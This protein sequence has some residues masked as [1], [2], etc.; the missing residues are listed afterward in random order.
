[1]LLGQVCTHWGLN[2]FFL[3]NPIFVI[4]LNF[5]Q[6]NPLRKQYLSHLSSENCEINCI[7]FDSPRAFQKHQECPQILIHFSIS[8]LSGFHWE[9][10]SIINSFHIIAPN[11]LKPSQCTPLFKSIPKIPRV[12]HQA[13]WFGTIARLAVKKY[14][15]WS[16]LSFV[17]LTLHPCKSSEEKVS[18]RW[19]VPRTSPLFFHLV[20]S[21]H[22]WS[23]QQGY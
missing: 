17:E 11:S 10:G 6:K 4:C 19:W 22:R 9:N 2:W 15:F 8:I 20:S 7:E 16:Q 18:K 21:G 5:Q 23:S 12:W 3:P 1:M 13:P 14:H